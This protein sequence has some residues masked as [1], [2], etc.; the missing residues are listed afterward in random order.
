MRGLDRHRFDV[1]LYVLYRSG[2][3]LPDV[4]QDVPIEDFWTRHHPPRWNWPGRVHRW[5]NAD[6]RRAI[7]EQQIDLVY[8]RL[9]HMSM[10][11]GNAVRGTPAARVSTIVSPPSRDLRNAERA[12][13]WIK[14]WL[15]RQSY[16]SAD[17]LLAVSDATA[18]DAA[19]FYSI[20]REKIEV[21]PSPID[22]ERIEQ[23]KQQPLEDSESLDNTIGVISIG[24]LSH[25]KGQAYLLQAFA[26]LAKSMK[27]RLHLH[28]VGDG[29]D[30][31]SLQALA[32]QLGSKIESPFMDSVPILMLFWLEWICWCYLR[33]TKVYP[34]C[35]SRG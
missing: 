26:M 4:P 17:R 8:D 1:R 30:R 9:F 33:S 27:K 12:F 3:L 23:L 10:I 5:Q 35:C 31:E 13:F 19:R 21:V 15:L 7:L 18:D 29:P 6:V 14:R 24:R 2:A 11:T 34:M 28:L 25:E 16:R 20:D 22:V 32:S